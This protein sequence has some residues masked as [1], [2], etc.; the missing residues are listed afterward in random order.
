ML[1]QGGASEEQSAGTLVG[2]ASSSQEE[3]ALIKI[4]VNLR[5]AF[6]A[7]DDCVLLSADYSQI[8]KISSVPFITS[9][10]V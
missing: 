5:S 2:S 8:G 7:R 3:K 4:G 10:A 9:T 1:L 6:A